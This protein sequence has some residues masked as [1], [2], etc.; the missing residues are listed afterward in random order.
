MADRPVTPEPHPA[1]PAAARAAL[2]QIID[3]MTNEEATA[4]WRL[5]CSWVAEGTAG[6]PARRES[7]QQP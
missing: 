6:R 5:I 2:H 7:E 3:R 1:S 4:L